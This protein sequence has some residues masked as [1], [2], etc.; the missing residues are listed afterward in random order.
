MH[1]DPHQWLVH[2]ATVKRKHVLLVI[3]LKTRYCMLFFDTKKADSAGFVH[4]FTHRWLEGVMDLMLKCGVL[5]MVAPQMCERLLSDAGKPFRMLQRSDRSSQG[6]L[7]EIL[8]V[9]KWD[10]EEFDFVRQPWSAQRYD[11]SINRTPR[12]IK[13]IKGYGYPVEEMLVHWLMAVGGVDALT[14]QQA[15]EKYRQ[16][17]LSRALP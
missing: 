17:S 13:G 1:G 7:N 11:A 5:D 10:A 2:A 6:Q 12:S 3:H 4:A 9:F 8:R 15:R 14:A 16:V